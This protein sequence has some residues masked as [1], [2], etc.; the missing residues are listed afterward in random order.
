MMEAGRW[1]S[2]AAAAAAAAEAVEETGAG[3]PSR[4]PPRRGLH[5]ASPYGLGPRRWLP[6]LPVASRIFP[7]MPRDRDASDNN[8]EVHRE[9]LEV[10]PERHSAEPNTTAAAIG[11]P[12]SVSNK[13]NLLLEGDYRNQS[14]G[15]ELAEIEKIINQRHFSRDE[16]ERLIEIMW[17]RT[18]DLSVEDQRAPGCTAKGFEATPFSTPAKLIDPQSSLGTDIFPPSNVHEVG[19]SPIEIAKA[20]MEAQTA[21]SVH[22]YQKRKFRALSHGVEIE[23]STSN[24]FPKIATDSSV[25][26][27]GSV[28]QDYPNYLT[29][30]STKGRTLPQPFSRTPYSGS[31]FRRSIKNSRHGDTYNN[32][33]GQSQLSTPFSVGSKTIPEDKLVSTSGGRVQPSSSSRGQ[34]DTFG[35]TTSFFPIEGS[36]AMK[37]I[38]FNLLGPHGK[39]TV[40][41]SSTPGC[42]SAID[43]ISRGGSVSVHPKS[44]ETAYKILQHLE[45][46]IPSP[47]SK[48]LELRQTLAKRNAS[49]VVTNN[50]FKGSDSNISNGYR[51][52]SVKASGNAYLEIADAKKVQV[53]PSSPNAPESSQKIQGCG[54]NSEVPETQ[55]SHYP[56]KS[57]LPS[58]SAAEVLDKNTSKGFTFTFPVAKAPSS[59]LEPPPTPTL[60]S[61][62]ARSL[63]VD[64]EEFPMFTFG[65]SSMTNNLVFSFDSSS[66]TN[67]PV[68][69]FDSTSGSVG[70]DGTDPTFKFGS[71]KKRE[72]SFDIAGKDAVCF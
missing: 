4:R 7:S 36:S 56:L 50:Q 19:S 15:N 20:F 3:G 33:S 68:F 45:K 63:P 69:S 1:Q 54:A 40:E 42:I 34:R 10:I 58:T 65:S 59:L 57:D 18:P 26:W 24:F 62:P 27:P 25:C 12:T 44:S 28:V 29:P 39:G 48:P 9:S 64:T 43:N 37:N 13:F 46:T 47:T 41:S 55:T 5:R 31:V 23:N 6:K 32:P 52:S 14:D 66:T 61:P 51:Q 71:D 11:Q 22:E 49:S 30:Q 2:P 38:T 8:Q 21:A 67:N 70:A 35:P 53:P 60:A 72:L 16:T 17:S